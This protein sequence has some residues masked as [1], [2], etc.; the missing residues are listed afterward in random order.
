MKNLG[1]NLGAN[2]GKITQVISAVVDVEFE[3][4]I[5]S[6]LHGFQGI[7]AKYVKRIGE[8]RQSQ[9]L[10]NSPILENSAFDLNTA[11]GAS[12]MQDNKFGFMS[13]KII[14]HKEMTPGTKINNS[15]DYGS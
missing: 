14:N 15:V 13:S 3:K 5:K 11:S 7:K 10:G 8:T 6:H 4:G 1:A 9:D 2:K 12:L